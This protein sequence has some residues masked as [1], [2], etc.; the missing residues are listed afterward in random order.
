MC[1]GVHSA[2]PD[3]SEDAVIELVRERI[4]KLRE[5]ERP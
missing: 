5:L 4:E 3:A 2:F 1:D